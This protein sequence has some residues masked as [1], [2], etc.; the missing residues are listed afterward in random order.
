MKFVLSPPQFGF[1]VAT[2]AALGVGIGLLLANRVGRSRRQRIGLALLGLGA[3]TTVPALR[4]LLAS[5]TADSQI[6]LPLEE[7]PQ[8]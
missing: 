1:I 3:A 4:N 2:R 6:A 8:M 7:P 5:R